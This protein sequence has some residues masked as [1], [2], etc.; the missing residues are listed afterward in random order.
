M[1]QR[2]LL[3][4]PTARSWYRCR[5]IDHLH[6]ADCN[7][8][9]RTNVPTWSPVTKARSWVAPVDYPAVPQD[10][11]CFRACLTAKH[12]RADLDVALNILEDT[13]APAALQHARVVAQD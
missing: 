6:H 11:I 1:G 10:R 9:S 4:C 7:R 3:P 5:R 8:R 12:S 2:R 13:L